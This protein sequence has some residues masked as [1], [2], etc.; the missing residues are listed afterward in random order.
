MPV[1]HRLSRN[2][3]IT[4]SVRFFF[5][6]LSCSHAGPTHPAGFTPCA[7]FSEQ[8]PRVPLEGGSLAGQAGRH[9]WAWAR[10]GVVV[11]TRTNSA[12]RAAPHAHG[13]DSRDAGG[14]ALR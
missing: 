1:V 5:G 9:A 2:P 8:D 3:R 11:G 10:R 13:Q 6:S 14:V 7:P 12:Q 4:P